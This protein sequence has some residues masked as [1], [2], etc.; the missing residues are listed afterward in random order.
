MRILFS[1]ILL[2]AMTFPAVSEEVVLE[3]Y[4]GG[5][6]YSMAEWA[7]NFEDAEGKIN[8]V[9]EKGDV[10]VVLWGAK[11]S[12][13]PS[14]GQSFDLSKYKTFQVDVMVAKGQ[15]VE[16]GSTFYLQLLS[17]VTTGYAYWETLVPQT[18]IPAD[19]KWYRI[20]LPIKTMVTGNGDGADAPKDR[21]TI[22]GCCVGMNHDENGDKF[23]FKQASFDNVVVSTDEVK[24]LSVS[25]RPNPKK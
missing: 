5:G 9:Y 20:K 19:G 25:L 2:S 11:W 6:K 10:A 22:N 18:K 4:Q 12:G 17:E 21:K 23:E 3:D 13:F 8:E 15:P 16:A 1:A 24:E 14:T 7:N